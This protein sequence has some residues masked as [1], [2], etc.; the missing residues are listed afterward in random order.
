VAPGAPGP[1]ERPRIAMVLGAGGLAGLAYEAGVLAALELEVGLVADRCDLLVGTSAGS[2]TA[3]V[4]RAGVGAVDLACWSQGS[5]PPTGDAMLDGL[6]RLRSEL[7]EVGIGA[8]VGRWRVPT[9]GAALDAVRRPREAVVSLLTSAL[10]DGPCSLLELAQRHLP[11]A[12]L[13]SRWPDGLWVC[14]TRR[15]DLCRVVLGHDDGPPVDLASA[16]AAS[17]GIPGIFTAVDVA[18]SE[19]VDGGLHSPTNADVVIGHGFELAVVVS[20]L[21]GAG[22]RATRPWLPFA[23]RRLERE[24]ADL[25]AAGVRTVCFEPGPD[26][27]AQMGINLMDPARTPGVVRSAYAEAAAS[28]RDAG[29]EGWAAA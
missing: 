27:A 17:S 22:R 13:S 2:V 18:G 19:L 6:G 15:T 4:L 9:V 1:G 11:A 12:W 21:T 8:L 14:A 26:A 7:P 20:P 3:A 5:V 28:V 24:L 16:I 25:E 10:P 23:R 29:L